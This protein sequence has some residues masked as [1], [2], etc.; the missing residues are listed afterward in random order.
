MENKQCEIRFGKK[1]LQQWEEDEDLFSIG[2]LLPI[3]VLWETLVRSRK[4]RGAIYVL[5]NYFVGG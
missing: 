5:Y 2:F 4:G 3:S 1:E